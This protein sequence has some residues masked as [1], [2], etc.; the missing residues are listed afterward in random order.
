MES[1]QAQDESA[2]E[3]LTARYGER[4]RRQLVGMSEMN[5]RRAIYCRR[6]S[7]VSGAMRL[8]GR[9]EAL[10]WDGSCA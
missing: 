8:N 5:R 9:G 10:C 6:S 2:F 1:V 4:I 3:E 7:S